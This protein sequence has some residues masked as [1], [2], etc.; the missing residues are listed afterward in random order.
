MKVY[1]VLSYSVY[2]GES[3]TCF[4]YKTKEEA[5]EKLNEYIDD[6]RNLV[7]EEYNFDTDNK[8]Y[9]KFYNIEN[10]SKDFTYVSIIEEEIK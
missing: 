1:I 8:T 6:F 5:L 10:S 4:V 7:D 9:A 2:H 3:D